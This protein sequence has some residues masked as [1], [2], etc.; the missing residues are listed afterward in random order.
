[1]SSKLS[2]EK[3]VDVFIQNPLYLIHY[4]S[5]ATSRLS[6]VFVFQ[7]FEHHVC[8]CGYFEFM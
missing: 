4:V 8:G 1:M 3:P 5:V 6:L 2:D 7:Q